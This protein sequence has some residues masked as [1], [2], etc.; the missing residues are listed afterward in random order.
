MQRR[1]VKPLWIA[2]LFVLA[3]LTTTAATDDQPAG[4]STEQ[5]ATAEEDDT[6]WPDPNSVEASFARMVAAADSSREL[7]AAITWYEHRLTI[8]PPKPS[9]N[10][11]LQL[12]KR[13]MLHR[14]GRPASG[15]E[16]TTPTK[17][18]TLHPGSI[19]YATDDGVALSQHGDGTTGTIA[20]R[21][22][23]FVY[24]IDL[25]SEMTVRLHASKPTKEGVQP[26]GSRTFF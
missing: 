3:V 12:A 4:Q 20:V 15:V 24:V 17:T 22:Q 7:R 23:R 21:T 5:P 6:G 14:L 25:Q 9:K 16:I 8:R 19:T 11:S 2:G 1:S 26:P 18:H 10:S 13:T